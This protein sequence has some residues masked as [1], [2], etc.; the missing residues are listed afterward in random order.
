MYMLLALVITFCLSHWFS[1][2]LF[3]L[4]HMIFVHMPHYS[5]FRNLELPSNMK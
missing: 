1:Y 4:K 5:K 2:V 3:P